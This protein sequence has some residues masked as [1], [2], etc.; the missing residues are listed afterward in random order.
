MVNQMF[1][2]MKKNLTILTLAMLLSVA[3]AFAQGGT[4]GPLTWNIDNGT[5]TISGEGAMPDYDYPDYAPWYQYREF[6][7]T[8]IIENGVTTIGVYAFYFCYAIESIT[9]SNS[10]TTIGN[11]AFSSCMTLESIT[12]PNNV[13][14][15]GERVF[16]GCTALVSITVESKNPNYS[17]LDG[18]LFD[19]DKT[20]LICYPAGK[21]GNNYAISNGVTTIENYAFYCCQTLESVIF[22][23]GVTTIGDRAFHGCI[24]LKSITLPHGVTTIGDNTFYAC[25]DLLSIDI[26]NGVTMIGDGAFNSCISLTSITLPTGVTTIGERT[27][28]GCKSLTSMTLPNGV[29]TIGNFAFTSCYALT[30]ITIPDGVITMGDWAFS[31]CTALKSITLPNDMTTIGN[32]AFDFCT[33]LLSIDIPGNVTT[34]GYEVFS[35][36]FALES[37]TV[38]SGNPTYSSADGVLFDKNKTVLIR[39]PVGKKGNNYDI[40]NDVTT[41]GR[42]AFSACAT[43]ESITIPKSVTTIGVYAFAGCTALTS[44]TNLNPV[45]VEINYSEFLSVDQSACTLKVPTSAVSAYQNAEVWKDFNIEGIEVGIVETDNYPSLRIYPNPTSGELRVTCYRHCGLDPQSPENNEIAGQARNDIQNV[46]VFDV[47]GRAVLVETR[48]ATSLQS[49]IAHRT[50]QITFDLSNVPAGIYFVRIQTEN[51]MVT[52]KVVKE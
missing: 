10:V 34:I 3:S 36:C 17:S 14:T 7:S 52:R 39:Y 9:I 40:P 31:S 25:M 18:V 5:L 1:R 29:T 44:I 2:N 42:S 38:E 48:H 24:A 23:N 45:P 37:I 32:F 35:Y 12:I 16:T 22:P 33:A 51:G 43:L 6:I 15:I 47:M 46:A 50:S 19:K 21:K 28:F 41:I 26:P 8:V 20:V 27:F 11:N 4:T 30:S 49:H 13:T